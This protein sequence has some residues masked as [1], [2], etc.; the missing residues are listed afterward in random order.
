MLRITDLLSYVTQRCWRWNGP[1]CGNFD[2]WPIFQKETGTGERVVV[3]Q[4]LHICFIQVITKSKWGGKIQLFPQVEVLV[5]ASSGCGV[6]SMGEL[7]QVVF[8]LVM[9]NVHRHH[10]D[11]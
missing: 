11:P 9:V 10:R 6:F 5:V 3:L 8:S 7:V 2:G 4:L 1:R